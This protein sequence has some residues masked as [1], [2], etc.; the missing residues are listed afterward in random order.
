M[1]LIENIEDFLNLNDLNFSDI[2]ALILGNNGDILIPIM[3]KWL[4]GFHNSITKIS[5][6]KWCG[7]FYTASAFGLFLACEILTLKKSY[8]N[9]LQNKTSKS[10]IKTL[11]LYNQ[12]KG[13]DH[14][15]ILLKQC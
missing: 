9:W 14:S 8:I 2:D 7:E 4:R 3:T 15:F 1:H 12:Y 11:L 10:E 6:K 5:Y 13:R